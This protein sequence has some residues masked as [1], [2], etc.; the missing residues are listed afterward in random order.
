MLTI[1]LIIIMSTNINHA[2]E[3]E[4]AI[5]GYHAIQAQ[6][7]QRSPHRIKLHPAQQI[8]KSQAKRFNVLDCGRRWG[9]TKKLCDL[10]VETASQGYPAGYFA[11]A[12]K[13]LMDGWRDLISMTA[14][15]Q[16]RTP[17]QQEKRIE[18]VGGGVIECWSLDGEGAGGKKDYKAGRSR[19]YKRVVIDEAAQVP[20]LEGVFDYAISPTLIDLMGDAWFGS[21]PNGKGGF[22]RFWR[23]GQIGDAHYDPDWM[24]WQMP[25]S[26]NPYIPTSEIERERRTKADHVFRQEYCHVADTEVRMM[27]G[28][29]KKFVEL[30]VGDTLPSVHGACTVVAFR[31]TGIKPLV[32]ITT[33]TGLNLRVSVGHNVESRCGK[34]HIEDAKD[35]EVVPAAPASSKYHAIARLVAFSTGDGNVSYSSRNNGKLQASFYSKYETDLEYVCDDLILAGFLEKRPSVCIK[36]GRTLLDTTYMVQVGNDAAELLVQYGAPLGKKVEIDFDVPDWIKQNDVSVKAEYLAA[37]WGAEGSK[38]TEEDHRPTRRC[39]S[40]VLSMC[41]HNPQEGEAFFRSLQLLHHDCGVET[42]VTQSGLAHRIYIDKGIHNERSF[43]GGIGYRYSDYKARAAFLWNNYYGAYLTEITNRK[44]RFQAAVASAG[45]YSAA[46]R[47]LG[48]VVQ[49]VIN[50]TTKP[51]VEVGRDFPFFWQWIKPREVA[52]RLFINISVLKELPSAPVYNITVSSPDHS[53]ILASGINN[54]NCA[55]FLEDGGQVF[56][57][58]SE[59]TMKRAD[60]W[61]EA[62]LPYHVYLVA[63]DLAKKEDFSVMG[64]IDCTTKKLVHFDHFNRVEY[65]I[66]IPRLIAM[67]EKFQPVEVVVEE[68]GNLALMEVLQQV[69]YQKRGAAPRLKRNWFEIDDITLQEI[70]LAEATIRVLE[71]ATAVKVTHPATMPITPFVATNVSKEE[72]IQALVLAFERG[73]IGIPDD[74]TLLGELEEFGMERLPSGKFKYSAPAGQHDDFVMMLAEGWYRARRYMSIESLPLRERAIRSLAPELQD[75][76]IEFSENESA[77]NSRDYHIR[78]YEREKQSKG[79]HFMNKYSGLGR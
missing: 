2:A 12:Y 19:K 51:S 59:C 70:M 25:T 22:Y 44:Q 28:D 65:M 55:E 30:K 34:S 42:T 32:E 48:C 74:I 35:L 73:E 53:Y 27:S 6:T 69:K 3:L 10:L 50:V 64:V 63:W 71:D 72:A 37:L 49:T 1:I 31:N 47:K 26:S 54:Y 14:N 78:A 29:I 13:Y 77:Y 75:G 45:S 52:G 68:N 5:Q 46:S 20:A 41:K 8:V 4:A 79:N 15:I 43:L 21:T 57:N 66:Q 38:P 18:L 60:I 11:P 61:Q 62:A 39:K 23:K 56:R 33:E 16:S 40:L 9:K 17:D 67:V 7:A 24:S 58:I 36:M 76:E